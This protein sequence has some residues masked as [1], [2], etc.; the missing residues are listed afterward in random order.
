MRARIPSLSSATS[1]GAAL[2][3][4][5]GAVA[6][7]APAS[8]QTSR[9]YQLQACV[10]S[11]LKSVRIIVLPQKCRKNER[12]VPIGST[13]SRTSPAIRYGVGPPGG[14][15]GSDGDFYVDTATYYFYGPRIAGNWGVGQSLVGPTGPSG[16]QGPQGPA[17]SSGPTG[18][19][20]PTGPTGAAG[21]A[22]PIGPA[23]GFGVDGSVYD[24]TTLLISSA[25]QAYPVPLDTTQ[26]AQG[27]SIVNGYEITMA[28]AGKY[29]L[30]F[31]LQLLNNANTR[32]IVTVWLSKNGITQ[33]N[34]LPWT[35]TDVYLGTAADTE[36]TVAAWNFFIDAAAG[37]HVVLMIAVNGVS[38]SVF[39]GSSENTVPAG[40]PLIPSTILTINQVG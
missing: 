3:L 8:A 9:V 39:A 20:G 31:S 7:A 15:L 30:A 23:G 12:A 19:M 18:A 38:V 13:E 28:E 5:L 10:H 6:V 1:V 14:S 33:A 40:L 37:D 11:K 25:G 35:S 16:A 2:L 22:G 34:W 21:P 26:F 24:T 27:V 32:R 29:N 17:G 4:V 36:R